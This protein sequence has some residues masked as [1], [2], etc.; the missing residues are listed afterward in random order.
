[1][2]SS[3]LLTI[4]NK[5]VA[6]EV[7]TVPSVVQG[8]EEDEISLLRPMTVITP[9][10]EVARA[11]V[12]QLTQKVGKNCNDKYDPQTKLVT[13]IKNNRVIVSE[14]PSNMSLELHASGVRGYFS[15]I[16]FEDD[17]PVFEKRAEN[18]MEPEA[19][20]QYTI[21]I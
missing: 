18:I 4:Q 13:V 21:N 9:K 7:V 11:E 12:K 2:L 16:V 6:S 15:R 19:D 1:M 3:F 8:S 10:W 17:R 20:K 14:E 5:S